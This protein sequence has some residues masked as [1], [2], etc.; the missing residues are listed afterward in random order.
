MGLQLLDAQVDGI[1]SDGTAEEEGPPGASENPLATKV[2]NKE[3]SHP[4]GTAEKVPLSD[5][6]TRRFAHSSIPSLF[7]MRGRWSVNPGGGG[8]IQLLFQTWCFYGNEPSSQRLACGQPGEHPILHLRVEPTRSVQLPPGSSAPLWVFPGLPKL[9]RRPP[10][11]RVP[12]EV[13]L[14]QNIVLHHADWG[15]GGENSK[16]SRR[17]GRTQMCWIPNSVFVRLGQENRSCSRSLCHTQK[18]PKGV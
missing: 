14:P 10:Y 11:P 1:L 17:F 9:S 4:W 2:V 3:P 5:T 8:Y 12:G 13:C 6:R 7:S 18:F 15:W 16:F